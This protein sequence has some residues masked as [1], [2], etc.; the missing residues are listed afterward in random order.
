MRITHVLSA[1]VLAAQPLVAQA[2]VV[3]VIRAARL[4]TGNGTQVESPVV[5][6]T[7]DRITAVGPAAAVRVPAGAKLIDLTGYTL[8]PG[9]FDMHT[10]LTSIDNDGGDLSVLK[11][12]PAHGAIYTT[13]NANKTLEAGFKKRG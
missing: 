3:T 8:M 6:V 12:T 2:P 1:F 13:I 5:V 7:G 11:E 4:I 9:F 10:H